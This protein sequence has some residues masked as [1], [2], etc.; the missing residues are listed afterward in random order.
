M[1]FSGSVTNLLT[2]KRCKGFSN[3][4]FRKPRKWSKHA[5]GNAEES[6]NQYFSSTFESYELTLKTQNYK[7]DPIVIILNS[8]YNIIWSSVMVIKKKKPWI[9]CPMRSNG[10]SLTLPKW[11]SNVRFTLWQAEQQYQTYGIVFSFLRE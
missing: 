6:R 11:I 9:C 4:A 10:L 3:L 1:T 8:W 7:I 2:I 5:F